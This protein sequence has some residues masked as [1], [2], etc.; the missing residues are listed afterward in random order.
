MKPLNALLILGLSGLF[1]SCTTSTGADTVATVTTSAVP[2]L[3]ERTTSVGL[4]SE[5]ETL[6]R[7]YTTLKEHLTTQPDDLKSWLKLSEVFITEARITGNYGPNY[8]AALTILDRVLAQT[9]TKT[10]PS[11]N[12]RGEALTLKALIKLSQ[13]EFQ[14]ALTLGEEAVALDPHRAFNYGILV[15]ANVELGDY[16]TAVTMSDKMVTIRPDLR[17]YSRVSYLREI[18]GDVPGAM[19]AMDLAVQAG[20]PGSEDHSWCRVQLGGLSERSGDLATAQQ[21][22]EQALTERPNYPFALAAL[23]RLAGKLKNYPEAEKQLNAAIALMP[24]AGFHQDLARVYA[25]QGKTELRD[26]AVRNAGLVLAGLAKGGEGHSHQVGL[27]MARY[28][29]EFAKDLEN[30]LINAQHEAT[31]RANNND[32]NLTL[33]AIHYAKGD[34]A[35]A[36]G[37]IARAKRTNSK[38]AYVQCLEGLITAKNGDAAKGKALVAESFKSDPYQSHPFAAEARRM[39]GI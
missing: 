39:I 30:A 31:H 29:L 5:A 37:F 9:T 26:E 28:Q 34:A 22:Y 14:E 3:P 35:T 6:Q 24:D 2:A 23:G 32:V 4:P 1:A 25:A 36:A 17:S 11:M 13:H 15:D 19:Q 7:T 33:A 10:G 38:D 20:Y 16:A 8:N 21:Q 12:L 18:H 27:E